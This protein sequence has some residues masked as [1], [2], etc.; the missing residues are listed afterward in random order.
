MRGGAGAALALSTMCISTP[1]HYCLCPFLTPQRT[2]EEGG[3]EEGGG[4]GT[5]I[6]MGRLGGGRAGAAG[7]G[8]GGGVKSGDHAGIRDLV[9]RLCQS[10]CGA[11]GDV[12]RMGERWYGVCSARFGLST[13][14]VHGHVSGGTVRYSTAL[15]RVSLSRNR[16]REASN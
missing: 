13:S 15:T 1:S 14:Y 10:R 7:G 11:R 6:I 2:K 5:G 12:S 3:D 16:P 9:Q 4:G 8:A